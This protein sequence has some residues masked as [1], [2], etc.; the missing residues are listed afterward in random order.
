M[1]MQSEHKVL[2]NLSFFL[3]TIFAV[4]FS[5]FL[6]ACIAPASTVDAASA[7]AQD[8]HAAASDDLELLEQDAAD[9]AVVTVDTHYERVVEEKELGQL[10]SVIVQNGT[11]FSDIDMLFENYTGDV[12]D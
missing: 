12:N 6:S 5:L 1:K 7:A 8:G 3:V 2:H 4:V 10:S 11:D 9:A